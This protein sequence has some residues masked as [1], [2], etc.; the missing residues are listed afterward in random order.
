[1]TIEEI[2]KLSATEIKALAYDT[3]VMI[4]AQ[5]KTLAILNQILSKKKETN[6]LVKA[7][8]RTA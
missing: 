7:E 5:S 1:M 6:Q 8:S 2:E 4:D 3:M